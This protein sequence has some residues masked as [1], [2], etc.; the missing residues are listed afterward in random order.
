MRGYCWLHDQVIID[1]L[2]ANVK[3]HEEYNKKPTSSAGGV[4]REHGRAGLLAVFPI[5]DAV[6][7]MMVNTKNMGFPGNGTLSISI[8]VTSVR[9][10][11]PGKHI[12]ALVG[13]NSDGL[14]P[15]D[16]R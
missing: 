3:S 6:H 7:D 5:V 8:N 1:W 15:M 10:I 2:E 13:I 9:P 4:R 12:L 14:R 16:S 11:C